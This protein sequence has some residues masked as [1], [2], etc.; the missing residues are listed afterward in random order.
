MWRAN[1]AGVQL[2][3]VD[4]GAAGRRRWVGSRGCSWGQSWGGSGPH[5]L[6]L[7]DVKREEAPC[8]RREHVLPHETVGML[9]GG[10]QP[11]PR[12]WA[13]D[14]HPD[15]RGWPTGG[16]SE[17]EE[18]NEA[19]SEEKEGEGGKERGWAKGGWRGRGEQ[20]GGR[21]MEEGEEGEEDRTWRRKKR[22]EYLP[23]D[24]ETIARNGEGRVDHLPIPVRREV[25]PLGDSCSARAAENS[26]DNRGEEQD[27]GKEQEE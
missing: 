12:H 13:V 18:E 20:S 23:L 25:W 1:A 11:L 27:G 5:L 26:R 8:P 10:C 7:G 2:R 6:V 19:E 3:D 21:G 15:Q 9:H 24:N 17:E 16:E 14:L 4:E 22:R